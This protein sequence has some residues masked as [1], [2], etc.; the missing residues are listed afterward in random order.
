M[1]AP[2][3]IDALALAD[4]VGRRADDA[5]VRAFFETTLRRPLPEPA[6]LDHPPLVTSAHGVK[7]ALSCN[8]R[9]AAFPP[10]PAGDAFVPWVS[11]ASF[12]AQLMRAGERL[13]RLEDPMTLTE[14]LGEP[15]ET[16][17]AHGEP[18]STWRRE[19]KPH[20]ALE[21]SATANCV[22]L[23]LVSIDEASALD[24]AGHAAAVLFVAWAADQRLLVEPVADPRAR[25]PSALF[26]Q[27]CPR[28]LW[29]SLFLERLR[30]GVDAYFHG[31]GERWIF[32]DLLETFGARTAA[33]GEPEPALDAPG[34]EHVDALQAHFSRGVRAR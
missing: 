34:W 29:D 25:T 13:L 22:P 7:L 18:V 6:P 20:V 10:V 26:E 33:D 21:V 24:G 19:L 16:L 28:G 5:V 9:H 31:D 11:W 30:P 12:R 4:L 32:D 27:L 15:S 2:P 1:N 14:L 23:V 3:P 17:D 8:V